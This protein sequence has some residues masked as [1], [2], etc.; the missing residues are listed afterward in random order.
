MEIRLGRFLPAQ[1]FHG[2]AADI[3]RVDTAPSECLDD[4]D[5]ISQLVVGYEVVIG[6]NERPQVVTEIYVDRRAV[7]QGTNAH[8]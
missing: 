4:G 5:A 8:R 3:A 7:I 1:A 6:G 2:E